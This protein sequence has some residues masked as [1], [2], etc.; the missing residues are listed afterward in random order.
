MKCA[1][2]THKNCYMPS[3]TNCFSSPSEELNLRNAIREMLPMNSFPSDRE[4]HYRHRRLKY[5]N[6]LG[7]RLGLQFTFIA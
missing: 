7:Y 6:T 5:K 2:Q 1:E 4:V 3:A